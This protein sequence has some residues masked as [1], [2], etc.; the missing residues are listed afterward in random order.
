MS[1]TVSFNL[2]GEGGFIN[3]TRWSYGGDQSRFELSFYDEGSG[4][5]RKKQGRNFDGGWRWFDRYDEMALTIYNVSLNKQ[6][7]FDLTHVALRNTRLTAECLLYWA[8]CMVL[9]EHNYH[10]NREMLLDH[11]RALSRQAMI[12]IKR[13][14]HGDGNFTHLHS[15]R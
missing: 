11:I 9:V 13:E 7:Y 3:P 1:D 4:T 8:K 5:F 14:I 6:A 15:V 12:D 10:T 2:F